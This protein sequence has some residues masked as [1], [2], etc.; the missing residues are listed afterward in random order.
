MEEKFLYQNP[1]FKDRRK[2]LR[3]SA[4]E[5]EKLL[6]TR[7]RRSQLG[8]KFIRQYSIGPY[9]VDFYCPQL[10]LAIELDG[11]VHVADDAKVYDIERDNY[12]RAHDI[13]VIRFWNDRLFKNIQKVLGKIEESLKLRSSTLSS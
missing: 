11:S 2:E 7:I 6:W 4:T 13:T 12:L 9:I 8:Y 10:R 3:N 1:I 5:A